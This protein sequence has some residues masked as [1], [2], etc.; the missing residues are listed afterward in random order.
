MKKDKGY[1][2]LSLAIFFV[3]GAVLESAKLN[4]MEMTL[5]IFVQCALVVSIVYFLVKPCPQQALFTVFIFYSVLELII[6]IPG[7]A[8]IIAGAYWLAL[9]VLTFF[10]ILVLYVARIF[11]PPYKD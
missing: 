1:S 3:A 9:C 2:S 8:H 5:L 4:Y 10:G 6:N 7:S 11:F